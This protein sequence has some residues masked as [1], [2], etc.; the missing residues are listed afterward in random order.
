[1]K[2]IPF[3]P[4]IFSLFM[5]GALFPSCK[6]DQIHILNLGNFSDTSGNLKDAATMA[7]IH[8]GMAVDYNDFTSNA[9]Y[10][11]VVK[12]NCDQV[13]F[14]NEMKG[15]YLL[16]ND[17]SVNFTQADAFL[18]AVSNAGLQVFGHTLI[19][20]QQQNATYLN[21]IVGGSGGGVSNLLSNGG[22]ESWNGSTP[23]GWAYY[24]QQNGNFSQGT[25]GANVHGGSYSL[26]VNV[27]AGASDNWRLQVA[28]PS[29]PV[30]QGHVYLVS[31][32]IMSPVGGS[33]YQVE[34]RSPNGSVSY[35]GNQPTPSTWT[36][37]TFSFTAAST[38]NGMIT[39]DMGASPN[40]TTYIDDVS[41]IDQTLA[42]QNAT[43]T[44]IAHRLDSVMKNYITAVVGHYAGKVV[45]W[46]VVN[47][48]FADNGQIR[49]NTNTPNSNSNPYFFV[50]SNYLGDSLAIKAFQYA[51]AADPKALLFIND[52]GLETNTAKLDSLIAYVNKLK[53][54][55]VPIDGI[56]TQMHISWN[57]P[58]AA[59]DNMFQQLASTGLKIRISEL[60]VKIN[61]Y[62][63]PNI[64]ATPLDEFFAYQA[65][66]YQYVIQSYLKNVPKNQ[67]YG[68][69]VWGVH[70]ADSWLYN[71]GNDFPLLFDV[72]FKKKPAFSAVLQALKGNGQ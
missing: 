40:G 56:G 72:N 67:Q 15:Q 47:E 3:I 27:T 20:Y 7:G 21:S 37:K 28:S 58:P 57:T 36:L 12:A 33:Q 10:A 13:T 61:P 70:D 54:L 51:R 49:N 52:Y 5:I 53:S 63:K 17:G 38:G 14:E 50:W 24:N 48:L 29:F 26:A 64:A 39:F 19:W 68:I 1:M 34:G 41:V 66:E 18:N 59:I 45:A 6:K 25:G 44:A 35:S 4:M 71:N 42:Q 65:A 8:F 62:A 43:P 23:T 55:G 11:S 30:V 22:F 60:D 69:T 32:W 46:D 16:Q 31:F 9:T 2:K